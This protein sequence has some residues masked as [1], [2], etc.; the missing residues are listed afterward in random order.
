MIEIILKTLRLSVLV[1]FC[2]AVFY[3]GG[4]EALGMIEIILKTLRL[5]VLVVFCLAVFLWQRSL[6]CTQI[7]FQFARPPS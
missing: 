4:A 6:Y 5:S 7:G 2:L 3:R 1:V